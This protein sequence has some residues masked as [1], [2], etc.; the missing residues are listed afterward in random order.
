MTDTN[1]TLADIV[2]TEGKPIE[3]MQIIPTE[4]GIQDIDKSI[5]HKFA[6]DTDYI[7]PGSPVE[8][9][10]S[11]DIQ[12]SKDSANKKL[13][14]ALAEE[15]LRKEKEAYNKLS[16]NEKIKKYV[17]EAEFRQSVN[18]FY[19]K[20][21][22][23]MSGAQ[24]RNVKRQIERAWKSGKIKLTD[25]QK[26]DILYEMNRPSNTESVTQPTQMVKS[27]ANTATNLQS[28]ITT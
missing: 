13:L 7:I 12:I 14:A 27:S 9:P 16:D 3:D 19:N 21:G 8:I 24:K 4:E 26:Q 23:E 6:Y 2:E 17:F 5:K 15:K 1:I 18:D 25:E 11:S 20:H 28:L 22:Y 10:T